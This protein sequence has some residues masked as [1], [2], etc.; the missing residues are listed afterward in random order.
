MKPSRL[1][2]TTLVV[3]VGTIALNA[4]TAFAEVNA[5]P[6][7]GWCKEVSGTGTKYLNDECKLASPSGKWEAV[8][9]GA[10]HNEPIVVGGSVTLATSTA[11]L[12]AKK[13]TAVTGATLIGSEAPNPGGSEA[14][15]IYEGA[16][17]KGHPECKIE[18]GGKVVTNLETTAL[19]GTLVYLTRA[20]AEKATVKGTGTILQ[21][22]SGHSFIKF[23]L[24]GSECPVSGEANGEG[25]VALENVITEENEKWG[26]LAATQELSAPAS[27]IKSYYSYEGEKLVEKTPEFRLFE[28]AATYAG[29]LKLTDKAGHFW[30]ITTI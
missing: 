7:N 3:L 25:S 15:L 12:E 21:P 27:P 29:T 19:V 5:N 9:L 4:A 16:S 28:K 17:V 26:Q 22:K 20:A 24:S 23:K 2:A 11:I 13:L 8:Q 10:G 6:A 30:G 18:Q 14:T 1:I